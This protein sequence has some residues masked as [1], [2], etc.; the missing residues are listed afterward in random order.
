M[1]QNLFD[2]RQLT[3]GD[4][5]DIVRIVLGELT[6]D[7]WIV[8]PIVSD[9]Q[10]ADVGKIPRQVDQADPLVVGTRAEPTTVGRSP[11]GQ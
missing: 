1:S 2:H 11:I 9:Q 5:H 7:S 4:G 3:N 8:L 10:P 6:I